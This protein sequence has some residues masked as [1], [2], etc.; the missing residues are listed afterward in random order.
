LI[1]YEEDGPLSVLFQSP[2]HNQKPATA[3]ERKSN[4]E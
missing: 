1:L 3:V 4:P 2:P